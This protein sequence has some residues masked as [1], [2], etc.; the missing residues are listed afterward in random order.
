MVNFLAGII[1]N[2]NLS[3]L[4]RPSWWPGWDWT[5][6]LGRW[7]RWCRARPGG[8]RGASGGAS[9]GRRRKCPSRRRESGSMPWNRPSLQ[10]RNTILRRN[11]VLVNF[12]IITLTMLALQSLNRNYSIYSRVFK[13]F[14]RE[15]GFKAETCNYTENIWV[16]RFILYNEKQF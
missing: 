8:R 14:S 2:I 1:Y 13:N 3:L 15:E 11:F 4:P 7:E 16:L 9:P 10:P 12:E 6:L 5:W